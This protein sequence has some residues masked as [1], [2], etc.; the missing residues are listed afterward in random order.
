MGFL[1]W[2]V[3]GLVAGWLASVVMK[4]SDSQGRMKDILMGII[5]AVVGG[6]VMEFFGQSGVTGLNVYSV[7]VATL[8][9]VVLIWLGR[10]LKR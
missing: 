7:G 9:A 3:L 8:G 6:W 1:S 2:I 5:G 4:T 10:A